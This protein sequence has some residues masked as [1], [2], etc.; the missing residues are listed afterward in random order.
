MKLLNALLMVFS[1]MLINATILFADDSDSQQKIL[2][3]LSQMENEISS[4]KQRL[5]EAKTVTYSNSFTGNDPNQLSNDELGQFGI[6]YRSTGY[7]IDTMR[8]G[9]YG[10]T[11]LDN[12][13]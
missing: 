7:N 6:N 8:L 1:L 5:K 9:A 2:D 12:K 10:E 4:L 11:N 13:K 3:K